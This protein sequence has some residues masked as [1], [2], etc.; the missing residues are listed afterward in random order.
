[1]QAEDKESLLTLLRRSLSFAKIR[2]KTGY[3]L[4][5]C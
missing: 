3:F 4:T 2:K 5:C 1:V